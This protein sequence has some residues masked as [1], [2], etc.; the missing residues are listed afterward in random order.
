MGVINIKKEALEQAKL[1]QY[2]RCT[3]QHKFLF[4]VPNGGSRNP[5]EAHNLKL[6]GVKPGVPDIF[7]PLPNKKYH[8]LFIEMKFG[9][10]K[11]TKN[12]E[13]WIKYLNSVG[14]LAVVCY[15]A[16]EAIT[17]L[18]NYVADRV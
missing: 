18:N 4:H 11:P 17:L 10:N 12:Q 16:D 8:G 15:S 3:N 7:Y 14:Y 6:Q 13:I 5:I 2:C 9:K 1:F